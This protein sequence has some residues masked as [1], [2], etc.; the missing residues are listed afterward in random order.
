LGVVLAQLHELTAYF[1]T[2]CGV[3]VFVR[4]LG[5]FVSVFVAVVLVVSVTPGQEEGRCRDQE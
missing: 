4:I 5:V 1:G 3:L 2:G